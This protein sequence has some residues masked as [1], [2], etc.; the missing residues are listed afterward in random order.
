MT[1]IDFVYTK[2]H[3]LKTFVDKSLKSA[4]SEDPFNNN[5]AYGP[6]HC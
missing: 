3:T 6:K 1:L 5:I 2:L 4:V